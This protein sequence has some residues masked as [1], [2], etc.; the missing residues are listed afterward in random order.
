MSP[1]RLLSPHALLLLSQK[2]PRLRTIA[3]QYEKKI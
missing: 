1:E 3:L 2:E